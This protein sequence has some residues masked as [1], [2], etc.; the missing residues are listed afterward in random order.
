MPFQNIQGE[1]HKIIGMSRFELERTRDGSRLNATI[2]RN[3]HALTLR[4]QQ[5]LAEDLLRRKEPRDRRYLKKFD[6]IDASLAAFKTGDE[7]M[8][9]ICE[10]SS[11]LAREVRQRSTLLGGDCKPIKVVQFV[12]FYFDAPHT[13]KQL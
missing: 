6:D 13:E 1:S 12:T 7:R 10:S 5:V 9:Q 3:L 4:S 11:V 8:I 2:A